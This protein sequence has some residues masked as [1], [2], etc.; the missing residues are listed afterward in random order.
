MG[1]YIKKRDENLKA[2]EVRALQVEPKV[3]EKLEEFELIY[4]LLEE[5]LNDYN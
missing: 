1:L 5:K 3:K 4:S 2:E